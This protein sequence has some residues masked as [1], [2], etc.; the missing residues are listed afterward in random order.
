MNDRDRRQSFEL[1][2]AA[3]ALPSAGPGASARSR[4]PTAVQVLGEA[5]ASRLDTADLA[6]LDRIAELL[7]GR[8]KVSVMPTARRLLFSLDGFTAEL[9]AA[10]RHRPEVQLV[11]LDRLYEGD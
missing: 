11:D 6:R 4:R 8:D 10:A 7:D 1:D 5:K 9:A 2:V 3:A